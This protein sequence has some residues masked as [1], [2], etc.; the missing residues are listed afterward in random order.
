MILKNILPKKCRK[1]NDQVY[2]F[3]LVQ[4]YTHEVKEHSGRT[5]R[6]DRGQNKEKVLL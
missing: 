6:F 4:Y 2:D 5:E 1:K 3:I